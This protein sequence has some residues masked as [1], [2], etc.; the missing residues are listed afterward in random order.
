[1]IYNDLKWL[2]FCRIVS[3][4][5]TEGKKLYILSI[6]YSLLRNSII[7]QCTIGETVL[8]IVKG[9]LGQIF[10]GILSRTECDTH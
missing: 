8:E 7:H 2:K 4:S 9:V 5:I 1:M 10:I 3:K 6:Y